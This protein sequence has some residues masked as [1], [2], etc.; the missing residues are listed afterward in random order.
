MSNYD[1]E[2]IGIDGTVTKVDV[3]RVLDA[4]G[5]SDPATQHAIK[6]MLCTGLRGHKDYLTDL[7]DSIESLQKA[8]ELYGQRVINES[9]KPKLNVK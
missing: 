9:A 5:V 1:R 6:K 8:K 7:N 2:I 4:F 3:Y